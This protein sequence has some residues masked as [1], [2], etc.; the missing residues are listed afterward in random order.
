MSKFFKKI[1]ILISSIFVT[2][3]MPQ[4]SQAASFRLEP[5]N[6]TF[7]R[8]CNAT[9]QIQIST[10]GANS[11]AAD[12][13]LDYSAGPNTTLSIQNGTAFESYAGK[14]VSNGKITMTGFSAGS[15][16]YTGN[17]YKLFGNIIVNSTDDEL[18]IDFD[19]APNN[20][21][22][23]NIADADNGSID[24][25]NMVTGG[26]YTFVDG[27]CETAPPFLTDI[28]P[29][30]DSVGV[31]LDT[32]ISFHIK[33][34]IAGVDIKTVKISI[35]HNDTTIDYVPDVTPEITYTGTNKDY[36]MVINPAENFLPDLPIQVRVI[37]TDFAGNSMNRTFKYNYISCT[38]LG[39]GEPLFEPQCNDEVDND[40]DGFV[41][42]DDPG[43][44]DPTDNNEYTARDIECA[45]GIDN[46]EDGLIDGTDPGCADEFDTSE[47]N[48]PTQYACNDQIDNDSDGKI[49]LLDPDCVSIYDNSE[50]TDATAQNLLTQNPITLT[51]INA[52]IAQRTIQVDIK[53]SGSLTSMTY[54][55]ITLMIDKNKLPYPKISDITFSLNNSNY[56]FVLD[57]KQEYYSAD[58]LM[59]QAGQY[60]GKIQI[61][62][63]DGNMSELIVPVSSIA[64]GNVMDFAF[65][66]PIADAKMTL[67]QIIGNQKVLFN[68]NQYRQNNPVQTNARGQYGFVVPNGM[69][70]IEITH[71]KYITKRTQRFYVTNNTIAMPFELASNQITS[72]TSLASTVRYSTTEGIKETIYS[73]QGSIR[74]F[75]QTIHDLLT[76]PQQTITKLVKSQGTSTTL[77]L[78]TAPAIANVY[79]LWLMLYIFNYATLA[80]NASFYYLLHML[81]L[82][83]PM[84]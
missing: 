70:Q 66:T 77:Q 53:S 73:T 39:C 31:A 72:L 22:D 76:A 28:T 46:D 78:A 79:P 23:S 59:P 45:D 32:N 48:S 24:I 8:G 40:Q 41:D 3:L 16:L 82:Y 15:M 69:Y 81:G 74:A 34:L 80:S 65:N 60:A 57:N 61:K 21:T 63:T 64:Y 18:D 36:A 58:F 71:P 68:A 10:N 27:F 29:A 2:L 13:M 35:T 7:I 5:A 84:M 37:A 50:N 75:T 56:R 17:E 25:L 6:A 47:Y 51:D 83:H 43:C 33:D 14:N 54:D 12:A 26:S 67:Y 11:N 20:P 49:D 42:M 38:D 9:I 62:Y 1:S 55:Q 4:L 19:Y 52:F 30:P 44:N